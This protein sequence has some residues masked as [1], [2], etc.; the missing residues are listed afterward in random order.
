MGITKPSKGIF[1]V[2]LIIGLFAIL[3]QFVINIKIPVLPEVANIVIL[4]IAL[5]LLFIGVVFKKL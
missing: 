2:S 3:N 1:W 5:A 4:A